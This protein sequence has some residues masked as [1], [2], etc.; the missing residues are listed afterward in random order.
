MAYCMY[1]RKS[2][3]DLDAEAR[4]EGETLA[5]H[6][7]ALL[8]LGR[9][10]KLT[11]TQIYREIVS[12]E[13]ISARPVM[14]QLL[15]EVERGAWDGVL[16]MEVERLARGDTVD[17]GIVAQ[18]FQYSNTRIITPI[19]TYDPN[20]EYDEEYFEFGL[21]MSRREY[22]TINRR[23][24][25][26]RL[27]S[28][29]EGKYVGSRPPYGY[30]R[31]KLEHDK[32]YTLS[33][34]PE[35]ARIVEMIFELF[36]HGER[37]PDGTVEQMGVAKI[38]R[39]LNRLGI[40]P[41][42]G[43]VWVN[44]TIQS[45]LRNPVYIGKI[46]WNAR[47]VKKRMTDGHPVKE[48][49]RAKEKE[50]VLTEGLH[51]A[52]IDP[53]TWEEARRRLR[54][55]SPIPC[56]KERRVKN[57][58]AGLVVCG[59]CGRRMARRPYAAKESP[60]TLICPVTSCGNVSSQLE[61][62]EARVLTALRLWLDGYKITY[63]LPPAPASSPDIKKEAL[64][65]AQGELL[66]LEKQRSRIYNLL[67]DGTYTTDIFLARFRAVDDKIAGA[68]RRIR[69]IEAEIQREAPAGQSRTALF[70]KAERV[71]EQ[72]EKAQTPA[73]KN[74]LLKSV[75]RKVVYTKTTNGRW[76]GSPDD[77]ELVLYP[78]IPPCEQ[79]DR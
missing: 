46:R 14:Q 24:Q 48:R 74:E 51:D 34:V 2:R 52:I 15:A 79:N 37:R 35:Q 20:N 72:Y 31:V 42:K 10:L 29:Q 38:V 53:K 33:P 45:M 16:V 65:S 54:E 4:G 63:D 6:E 1:L 41:A 17:Q 7:K 30:A 32:G 68:Q 58:L 5:R 75:I 61:L 25:R 13:T 60:D 18:T 55:N 49:P 11:I 70:P 59:M 62:V 56:P 21:F 3:A 71:L 19:K 39:S 23:L 76:H 8:E 12:G 67:E 44:A 66:A 73:E 50:W 28:V 43:D 27:A 69:Q 47:P 36:T 26:G 9:R 40:P 77:F 57:P 64:K 22:K 78:K